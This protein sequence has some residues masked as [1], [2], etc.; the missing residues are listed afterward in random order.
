MSPYT[1]ATFYFLRDLCVWAG[2]DPGW[3]LLLPFLPFILILSM[4][5][6][7]FWVSVA[8]YMKCRGAQ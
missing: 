3:L 7:G 5:Y 4:L 6:A 8:N 2:I 1:E